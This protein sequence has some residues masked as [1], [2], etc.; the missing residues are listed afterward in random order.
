MLDIFRQR[1]LSNVIYG[2]IIVATIFAFVVTFRPQAQNKTASLTEACAARVRGRCI[3]PKDF[4]SAH[5]M[6]SPTRS[7]TASRKLNLK[8]AALDGLVERELMNDDAKRLGLGITDRELT[9]QLFAG[10]VRVSVPAADP[11]LAQQVLS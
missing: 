3:D 7:E 4:S 9:D 1:G 6:L 8:K 2:A 5:R 10:Y 11:E